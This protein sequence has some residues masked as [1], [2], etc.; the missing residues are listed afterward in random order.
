MRF[1]GDIV[2][3]G[4]ILAVTPSE[5]ERTAFSVRRWVI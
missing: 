3:A 5:P 2:A 1:Y 4:P